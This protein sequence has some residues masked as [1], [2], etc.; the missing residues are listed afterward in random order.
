MFENI[1]RRILKVPQGT[2]REALYLET[3][4]LSPEIVIKKKQTQHGSTNQER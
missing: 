1:I 4:L 3:G 2:P